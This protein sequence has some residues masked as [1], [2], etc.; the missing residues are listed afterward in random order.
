MTTSV[1]STPAATTAE[2]IGAKVILKF[3]NQDKIHVDSV[4]FHRLLIYKS[5]SPAIFCLK[6]QQ[7]FGVYLQRRHIILKIGAWFVENSV[8]DL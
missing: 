7:S 4:F 5:E 6:L 1:A 2:K 8:L 3:L